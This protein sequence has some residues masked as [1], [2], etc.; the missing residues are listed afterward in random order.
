MNPV[1]IPSNHPLRR[2]VGLVSVVAAAVAVVSLPRPTQ[3][4]T[5]NICWRAE[6][7]GSITFYAATYH[8]GARVRGGLLINSQRHDFT[9]QVDVLP[10]DITAC[11]P[12]SCRRGPRGVR[13]QVV[14]LDDMEMNNHTFS[15]TC[16]SHVEC[17]VRGCYVQSA[18]IG[19]CADIDADAVCDE[20]DNCPGI[21]NADQRDLDGD[22]LGDPCDPCPEQADTSAADCDSDS[23]SDDGS[24][25]AGGGGGDD[26][27]VDDEDGVPAESD[28]CPGTVLPESVPTVELR[29]D[30]HADID[31]DG[32][33]ETTV[34]EGQQ[35][36]PH[37]TLVDTGGCS[38]E[39]IVSIMDLGT[40]NLR[41]GCRTDVLD[42]WIASGSSP[43]MESSSS[44][45]VQDLAPWVPLLLVPP[46]LLGRRYFRARG[47]EDGDGDAESVG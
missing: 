32:E 9:G 14:N 31:G 33:F 43:A 45:L 37:Y 27:G 39:Q 34:P 16:T 40:H 28:R 10:E 6:G 26:G 1:D 42:D 18:M 38:C 25:G 29:E 12:E 19:P 30:R 3:A 35:P 23:D 22:G 11:Q 15:T 41:Y 20:T 17:P 13:W 36:P 7:N 47:N 2:L 46:F 5:V 44:P 8:P 21:T 24:G 4:H